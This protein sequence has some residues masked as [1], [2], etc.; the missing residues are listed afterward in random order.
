VNCGAK[1]MDIFEI[2]NNF[3]GKIKRKE[4]NNYENYSG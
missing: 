4:K 2:S 3:A 1:V